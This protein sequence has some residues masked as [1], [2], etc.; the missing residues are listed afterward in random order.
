MTLLAERTGARRGT[1]TAPVPLGAPPGHGDLGAWVQSAAEHLGVEAEPVQSRRREVTS[2][3]ARAAPALVRCTGCDGEGF[4]VMLSSRGG[5]ASCL[6]PDGSVVRV[7]VE[8]VRDALCGD[9]ERPI[10]DAADEIVAAA[11][12]SGAAAARASRALVDRVAEDAPVEGLW[13]VRLPAGAPPLA[14]ARE[15]GIPGVVVTLLAG[16][17]LQTGLWV[18]SWWLLGRAALEGRVDPSW[19]VGWG[20]AVLAVIPLRLLDIRAGGI[21]ALRAAAAIRRRLLRGAVRLDPAEVRGRGAGGLLAETFETDALEQM[22]AGGGYL[23]ATAVLDLAAAGVVF[24]CGAG[25][26]LLVAALVGW[27]ALAALLARRLAAD[28]TRWTDARVALT[29]DTVERM[30]GHRTRLVQEPA[31]RRHEGEDAAA[32]DL[33]ERSRAMDRTSVLLESLLPRGWFLVGLLCVTPLFV[34]PDVSPGRIAAAL[35]G[36]LLAYGAFG[37]LSSGI[38][39]YTAALVAWRRVRSLWDAAARPGVPGEPRF[40]AGATK[41]EAGARPIVETRGVTFRPPGRSEV[42]RG[43]DLRISDG[44]RVLL[45]GP[46]GA[47][48]STLAS[49]L[50]GARAPG[51]GLV[52]QRGLD[53][54]TLGDFAWRGRVVLAPQFHENHVFTAPLL[55]NALMGRAWPPSPE[56]AAACDEVL[57][58]LGLADLVRRMPAGTGQMLGESGWQLSHGE[59]S[60]LYVARALLQDAELVVL[61]ESFGALDPATFRDVLSCV[62]S[63]ARTLLVIAHE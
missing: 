32:A 49:I 47:G 52:L 4:A 46:S 5:R 40:A 60:R 25:G 19:L 26:L 61:D 22:G 63:R 41:S 44:E 15:A 27:T 14:V 34:A 54:P 16:H 53:L 48:K 56:D 58:G 24:A 13:I 55:F 11:G 51:A 8:A 2:A 20:L 10:A 17:A 1:D 6:A 3:L 42:L 62:E 59:R 57:R 43:V 36:V 39:A 9:S 28:R 45:E 31:E 33:L 23:A 35:G 18:L 38:D 50:C 37:A 12:L 30:V 29:T 21:L 7:P